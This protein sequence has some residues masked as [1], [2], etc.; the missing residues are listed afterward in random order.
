MCTVNL[1]HG[2]A[3]TEEAHQAA[4]SNQEHPVLPPIS[5]AQFSAYARSLIRNCNCFAV[6]PEGAWFAWEMTCGRAGA[7]GRAASNSRAR[8]YIDQ[9]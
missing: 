2:F 9:N 8:R 6:Q 7:L 4:A 3:L 1:L 5:S